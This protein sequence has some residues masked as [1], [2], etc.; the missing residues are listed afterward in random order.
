MIR[1]NGERWFHSNLKPKLSHLNQAI[2]KPFWPGSKSPLKLYENLAYRNPLESETGKQKSD[3]ASVDDMDLVNQIEK[4]TYYGMKFDTS[5]G[6]DTGRSSAQTNSDLSDESHYSKAEPNIVITKAD[7]TH[8]GDDNLRSL[9]VYNGEPGFAHNPIDTFTQ[10]EIG[11]PSIESD[12]EIGAEHLKPIH[13]FVGQEN[14]N[15]DLTDI[16]NREETPLHSDMLAKPIEFHKDSSEKSINNNVNRAARTGKQLLLYDSSDKE[17]EIALGYHT[18]NEDHSESAFESSMENEQGKN[19]P[20]EEQIKEHTEDAPRPSLQD[21]PEVTNLLNRLTSGEYLSDCDLSKDAHQI[22]EFSKRSCT[23]K[24]QIHPMDKSD[25]EMTQRFPAPRLT[26]A[27]SNPTAEIPG[28]GQPIPMTSESTPVSATHSIDNEFSVNDKQLLSL[29]SDIRFINH[30]SLVTKQ[31]KASAHHHIVV[32]TDTGEILND[33]SIY[34]EQLLPIKNVSHVIGDNRGELNFGLKGNINKKNREHLTAFKG[35]FGAKLLKILKTDIF[36]KRKSNRSTAAPNLRTKSNK[37]SSKVESLRSKNYQE[38][39]KHKN[40]GNVV[41]NLQ[42]TIPKISS[43]MN[44]IITSHR[45]NHYDLIKSIQRIDTKR[46]KD[47]GKLIQRLIDKEYAHRKNETNHQMKYKVSNLNDEAILNNNATDNV[48][49]KEEL[50]EIPVH[51]T[52]TITQNSYEAQ[53]RG[54]GSEII[55]KISKNISS[56][57]NA[58]SNNDNRIDGD[59]QRNSSTLSF[60][61]KHEETSPQLPTRQCRV[62]I[63]CLKKQSFSNCTDIS[64]NNT[65]ECKTFNV[66][67]QDLISKPTINRM[68]TKQDNAMTTAF[69][70]IMSKNDKERTY[71]QRKMLTKEKLV[72]SR[73]KLQKLVERIKNL[74]K[75]IGSDNKDDLMNTNEHAGNDRIPSASLNYPTEQSMVKEEV[76]SDSLLKNR[77]DNSKRIHGAYNKQANFLYGSR[78]NLKAVFSDRDE[79]FDNDTNK[80]VTLSMS[81]LNTTNHGHGKMLS[82]INSEVTGG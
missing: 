75:K 67:S 42:S 64:K 46:K 47:S 18:N 56:N 52:T 13:V 68:R 31:R 24:N 57:E 65:N 45:K 59:Q 37:Y 14:N 66:D 23:E 49:V 61:S 39:K 74:E 80:T 19:A 4:D 70:N 71:F 1:D 81:Q 41:L 28:I 79:I 60:S 3:V 53:D 58:H 25:Y 30:G 54:L 26:P 5:I 76:D 69:S 55:M 36:E 16:G 38:T 12:S 77:F 73:V 72:E 50:N 9:P 34:S 32:D 11:H 48:N 40:D 78:Q 33:N 21:S 17:S 10:S 7:T 51:N 8:W 35:R 27:F 22:P 6:A 62:S 44:N 20:L 2:G 63:D 29:T 82:D 43:I 15:K